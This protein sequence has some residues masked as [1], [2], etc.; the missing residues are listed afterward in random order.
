M[1]MGE[2]TMKTITRLCILGLCC[3]MVLILMRIVSKN[4]LFEKYNINN[5]FVQWMLQGDPEYTKKQ[6]GVQGVIEI[7][8]AE[9]YPFSNEKN[10]KSAEVDLENNKGIQ[11]FLKKMQDE[12]NKAKNKLEKYTTTFLP[13]QTTFTEL[14]NRYES[15]VGW[16]L[17]TEIIVMENGYLTSEVDQLTQA[18]IQ[19]AS[20][21]VSDFN[22]FLKQDSIPFLYVNLPSKVCMLDKKM[23]IASNEYSNENADLFLED[24]RKNEVDTL[25]FREVLHKSGIDHYDAF[26]KTDHHW[27]T[28]TSFEAAKYLAEYLNIQYG[29]KFLPEFFEESSYEITTYEDWFLGYYGRQ[30]TLA[31][32]KPE[33]YQTIL[34]K[35]ESEFR[36]QIPSRKVDITD[37]FDK[38][39]ADLTPLEVVSYYEKPAYDSWQSKNDPLTI[40][41]N[42]KS[43]S[44]QNKKILILQDSFGMT[45]SPYIATG[46]GNL[47]IIYLLSFGGSVREYIRQTKPDMVILM[48]TQTNITPID[49]TI[50]YSSLDLR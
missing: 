47:D 38:A 35:F 23:P 26:Y 13:F 22:Q 46:V 43:K 7:N 18:D 16:N 34:P 36:V 20:E 21:S 33:N 6:T 48:Y 40:I 41:E 42:H 1:N 50:H 9:K 44:N 4:I 8:W 39:L 28:Q 3:M 31:N 32:A 45:L 37:S 17:Y 14:A 15:L 25:D 11:D 12:I 5:G 19:V 24:I 27:K 30:V 10:V 29:F 49:W 2:K